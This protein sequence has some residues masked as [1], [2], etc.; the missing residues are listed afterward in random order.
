MMLCV[1]TVSYQFIIGEELS[2]PLKPKRGLRQGDPLS[3]S[4]FIIF[5]EGLSALL[6]K[7]ED[8]GELY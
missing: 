4:L 2:G 3:P 8:Q 1:K 7:K 5:D 6:R